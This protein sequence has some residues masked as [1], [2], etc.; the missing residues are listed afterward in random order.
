MTISHLLLSEG[1]SNYVFIGIHFEER[2]LL[3]PLGDHYAQW[4][5]KTPMVLPGWP[6]REY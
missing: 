3:R 2:A 1:L 4:P 6:R 5:S